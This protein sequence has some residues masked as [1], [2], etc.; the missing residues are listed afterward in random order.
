VRKKKKEE[1]KTRVRKNVRGEE[2]GRLT[3]VF[4]SKS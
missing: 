3:L 2:K 1:E 4:S